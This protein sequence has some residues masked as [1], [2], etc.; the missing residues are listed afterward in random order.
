MLDTRVLPLSVL[1]N[2]NSVDVIV[3][4]LEALDRDAGTDVGEE[5]E[6]P[7]ECEVEGDMALADCTN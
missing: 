7:A 3:R 2:E 6:G 4:R 1:A 5:G